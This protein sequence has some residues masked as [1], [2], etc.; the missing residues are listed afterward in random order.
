MPEMVRRSSIVRGRGIVEY[1]VG[2]YAVLARGGEAPVAQGLEQ[3]T[4]WSN[5][6]T[7][8]H[9]GLAASL[10]FARPLGLFAE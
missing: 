9:R 5:P 7:R 3:R 6:L 4:R 8:H 2:R 10:A 1:D